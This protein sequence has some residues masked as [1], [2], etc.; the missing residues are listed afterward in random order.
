[1]KRTTALLLAIV[2]ATAFALPVS[3]FA[4]NGGGSHGRGNASH[5]SGGKAAASAK[6][7]PGRAKHQTAATSSVASDAAAQHPGKGAAK[8]RRSATLAEKPTAHGRKAA[9]MATAAAAGIVVPT[10]EASSTEQPAAE[11]GDAS[12]ATGSVDTSGS[13]GGGVGNAFKHIT[14]NLE[15]ALAKV[16]SGSMKQL[17]PGLVRVWLKFASWLGVDQGLLPGTPAPAPG[18]SDTS[19]S[20]TPTATPQPPAGPEPTSTVEPTGTVNASGT[21][22]L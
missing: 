16:E 4:K 13:V 20:V 18:S 7:S 3:A 17:P 5:A 22:G 11:S 10:S 12:P 19:G 15:K 8:A 14:A 21:A 9:A 6:T 2:L 1:M